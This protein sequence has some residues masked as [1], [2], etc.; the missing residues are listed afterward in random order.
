MKREKKLDVTEVKVL[1]MA[2]YGA[3]LANSPSP[4]AAQLRIKHYSQLYDLPEIR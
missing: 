2:L 1:P 4:P 3:E